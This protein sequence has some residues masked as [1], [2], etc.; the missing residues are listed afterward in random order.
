MLDTD[1]IGAIHEAF[2]GK[3][4]GYIDDGEVLR[5]KW[6]PGMGI[7]AVNYCVDGD[8]FKSI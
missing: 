7:V 8:E 4:G 3:G 1:K 6:T 5:E 2:D